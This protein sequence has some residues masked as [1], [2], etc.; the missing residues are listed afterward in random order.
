MATDALLAEAGRFAAQGRLQDALTTIQR[1]KLRG[2]E[3]PAVLLAEGQ[4]L[5]RL[6]DATAAVSAFEQVLRQRP[7]DLEAAYGKAL[8]H[9][10][11]GQNSQAVPLAQLLASK[12]PGDARVQ[13]LLARLAP[14]PDRLRASAQ[15][16]ATG[17]PAALREH[18][19]ALLGAGRA[20][21]AVDFYALAAA[22]RTDDAELH[23]RWGTALATLNRLDEAEKALVRATEL[24]PERPAAWQN[25][26]TVRER[27]HDDQGAIAAWQGLLEHTP[28]AARVDVRERI[29]RLREGR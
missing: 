17:D 4:V 2:P 12:R 28:E 21:E 20:G 23:L 10:T 8:A 16:A 15:A 27:R 14:E 25:L 9:L 3:D 5:A 6:G 11:L 18:G 22:R 19:D 24:S 7:E 29:R 13:R 26:A 1:A